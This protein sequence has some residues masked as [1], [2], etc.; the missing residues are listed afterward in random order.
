MA[1][2]GV[3]L[4]TNLVISQERVKDRII[5]TTNR[6]YPWSEGSRYITELIRGHSE[7][8]RYITEHIRGHSEGSRYIA[9]SKEGK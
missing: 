2:V 9:T 3:T 8:S 5:I 6:T 7:G 4:V 1:D